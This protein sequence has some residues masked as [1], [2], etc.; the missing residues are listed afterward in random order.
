LDRMIVMLGRHEV[1]QLSIKDTTSSGC[2]RTLGAI[3]MRVLQAKL[4]LR[5]GLLGCAVSTE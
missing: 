3:V 1:N 2:L 5:R 4:K